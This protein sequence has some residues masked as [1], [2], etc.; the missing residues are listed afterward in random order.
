MKILY[1]YLLPI[2]TT[3]ILSINQVAPQES[4]YLP[5]IVYLD[6]IPVPTNIPIVFDTV[7]PSPIIVEQVIVQDTQILTTTYVEIVSTDETLNTVTPEW[8][9][10]VGTLIPD[11]LTPEFTGP[12]IQDIDNLWD[13][14][15][16]PSTVNFG[17]E[18]CPEILP[19]PF[20]TWQ[21][22]SELSLLDGDDSETIELPASVISEVAS[23]GGAYFPTDGIVTVPEQ[24]LLYNMMAY[25]GDM[26][27]C[28]YSDGK[29][30]VYGIGIQ[31]FLLDLANNYLHY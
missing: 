30:N 14:I 28:Q 17:L 25:F 18:A 9:S 23:R 29:P 24:G 12:V 4:V 16:T 15:A 19:T 8:M 22:A 7:T 1:L 5:T 21:M 27:V 13:N 6:S 10:H 11:F 31:Y 3:I 26:K 2:I 20:V